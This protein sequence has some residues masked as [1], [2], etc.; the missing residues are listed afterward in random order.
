MTLGSLLSQLVGK[1]SL[2]LVIWV[3]VT[4]GSS[5]VLSH[6]LY[7]SMDSFVQKTPSHLTKDINLVDWRFFPID[8][9]RQDILEPSPSLRSNI[10]S[11]VWEK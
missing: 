1:A 9:G 5:Q 10:I 8:L 4:L 7:S 2:S 6:A 3:W 11:N